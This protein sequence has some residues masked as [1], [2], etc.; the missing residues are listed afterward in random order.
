ML[1]GGGSPLSKYRCLA[2]PEGSGRGWI[3]SDGLLC[4]LGSFPDMAAPNVR[5]HRGEPAFHWWRE[6]Y[7]YAGLRRDLLSGGLWPLRCGLVWQESGLTSGSRERS[8]DCAG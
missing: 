5:G 3:R 6:R 4:S 7:W 8:R 1:S 2:E